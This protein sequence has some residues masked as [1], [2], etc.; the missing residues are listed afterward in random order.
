MKLHLSSYAKLNLYLEILGKQSNGYHRLRTVFERIDLCD[1]IIL[2]SRQDKKI[3]ILTHSTDIPKDDSNIAYRAA[4]QLQ[5]DM[6]VNKGVD[7]KIIK[8]IPVASGLGGGS[9]NAASVIIGLNKLW[10]LNLSRDKLIR[11]GKKIGAD[12]PFF[13]FNCPFAEGRGRGDLI[14]PL[15]GL[16][17]V[18]LWH[19][20]IVPKISVSTAFIYKKWDE[21]K[22]L[23]RLT[24]TDYNV[25]ILTLAL[26]KR[27][28]ASVSRIL[29]NSLQDIT[30]KLYPEIEKIKKKLTQAGLKSILMSG[31]GPAVFGICS[32]RK[33]ARGLYSELKGNRKWQVF[34][35]R[36]I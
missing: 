4:L 17:G 11:L 24:R 19:I 15:K 1:K 16:S 23:I 29:F 8:R 28:Y 2:N 34:L 32:S 14:M 33:E 25:N 30:A 35:T 22:H 10:G 36:T 21:V 13:I 31:S 9:S 27:D 12:V 5:R 6:R 26:R 3:R 18:R 20:L 7:I